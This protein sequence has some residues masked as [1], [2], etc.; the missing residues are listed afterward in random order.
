M[1][2]GV[3]D[4][5]DHTPIE[6]NAMI[7]FRLEGAADAVAELVAM[8]PL[9]G[10]TGFTFD[11]ATTKGSV[12]ANVQLDFPFKRGLAEDDIEYLVD[13]E[14]KNFSAERTVRD[15]RVDAVNAK[16]TLTAKTI[17]VKG[18]GQIAGAPATFEYKRT[19]GAFDAEFRLVSTLD[20]AARVRFGIDFAPWLSGLSGSAPGP[21]DDGDAHR[22]GGGP[23][24]RAR[25][26]SRPGWQKPVGRP[27]GELPRD[28]T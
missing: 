17:A 11:P 14:V 6:P 23:H 3:L 27:Q 18:D 26:R 8:D 22:R 19:K 4:I 13:A 10:V 15:Q 9:R 2:D 28:R 5:L 7:K 25:R 24:R 12:V 20:D 16:L 1:R 21:R